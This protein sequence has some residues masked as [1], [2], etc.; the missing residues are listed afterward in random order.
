MMC[1]VKRTAVNW[2]L[3]WWRGVGKEVFY[4][5]TRRSQ[6]F[7]E[8]IPVDCEPHTCFSVF[9]ITFGKDGMARVAGVGYISLPSGQLGSDNIPAG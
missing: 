7:S 9:S 3:M 1:W 6:C 4:S 5:S 2:S 8:S